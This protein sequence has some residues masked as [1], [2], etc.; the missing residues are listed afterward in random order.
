MD[1]GGAFIDRLLALSEADLE[2]YSKAYDEKMSVAEQMSE[3]TYKK[4]FE[5]VS[6]D[7]EDELE[8]AFSSLPKT[9]EEIGADT[10]RGFVNGLTQN[11]DY[12]SEEVKTFVAGMVDTFKK[13]LKISSP[14]RVM[15][16]IGDFTGQGFVDG[17][18]DTINNVK[19]TASK[20]AEA[21]SSPLDTVKT[22]IGSVKTSVGNGNALGGQNNS[23][24]NNYNLTQNNTSPKSLSAL[25]TY[26]ARRQQ[27]ALVKAM[28]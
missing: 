10:M 25:E 23:V 22:N 12:L 15:M 26:Q 28:T 17:L 27:V 13:E 18:K 24:V 5:K 11:T 8:D 9:L 2:A 1:Q 16:S 19:K 14:S 3:Q 7:Y 20:M 21:V 4:D 6:K